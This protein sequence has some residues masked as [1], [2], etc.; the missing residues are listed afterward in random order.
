[1]RVILLIAEVSDEIS[2][3]EFVKAYMLATRVMK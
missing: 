2:S 3:Y 1:M